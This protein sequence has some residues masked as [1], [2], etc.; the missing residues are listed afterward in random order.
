[1]VSYACSEQLYTLWCRSDNSSLPFRQNDMARCLRPRARRRIPTADTPSNSA[2]TVIRLSLHKWSELGSILGHDRDTSPIYP[3][4]LWDPPSILSKGY[5]DLFL[6]RESRESVIQ[7]THPH[8]QPNLKKF[9][10]YILTGGTMVTQWLRCCA[11]NRKVIGLIPAG[12]TGIFHR[13]KILPI[14][15]WPQGRL[16]L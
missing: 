4:W 9:W 5:R 13:H 16:S 3:G 15:L 1:M 12:V 7:S 11:A 8:T 6:Q 10:N 2:S 14:A